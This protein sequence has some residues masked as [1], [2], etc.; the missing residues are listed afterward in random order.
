MAD[1]DAMN[2]KHLYSVEEIIYFLEETFGNSVNIRNFIRLIIRLFLF[3][4]F[5]F[6]VV[7]TV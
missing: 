3:R 2:A 1:S 6:G 7:L 5:C 4:N